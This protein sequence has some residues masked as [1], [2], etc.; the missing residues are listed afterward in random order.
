[1]ETIRRV[2]ADM[3]KEVC[4]DF[5]HETYISSLFSGYI[6][7][8]RSVYRNLQIVFLVLVFLL[9]NFQA[10]LAFNTI[11]ITDF[12][13]MVIVKLIHP[14]SQHFAGIMLQLAAFQERSQLIYA[15][16]LLRKGIYE[17]QEIRNEQ[18]ELLKKKM[19]ICRLFVRLVGNV[20]YFCIVPHAF[21]VPLFQLLPTAQFD[22]NNGLLNRYLAL[23]I[24]MLFDTNS[25]LGFSAAFTLQTILF[26][27]SLISILDN[28]E[29][30]VSV[31]LQVSAQLDVLKYSLE[32]ISHR[33]LLKF[34]AAKS[35]M[36]D[37]TRGLELPYGSPEFQQYHLICLRENIQH[38]IEI[39]RLMELLQKFLNKTLRVIF[40]FFS[41][42]LAAAIKL[43]IQDGLNLFLTVLI[44]SDV[45]GFLEISIVCQLVTDKSASVQKYLYSTPWYFCNKEYNTL[46]KIMLTYSGR[47]FVVTALSFTGSVETFGDICSL[48]YK[49]VNVLR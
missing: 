5:L 35:K 20:I 45:L 18:R 47:P 28:G 16:E 33:A 27:G 10:V 43:T 19:K 46:L 21:I 42:I 40:L 23:P 37:L 22:D 34:K 30:V 29:L 26:V 6:L 25:V 41:I 12:N 15:T 31:A 48:G 39:K 17:Y 49:T 7:F 9:T 14:L 13:K 38:H 2:N 4:H 36:G 11:I 44:L 8:D 24:Y 32:N 3:D 1:M